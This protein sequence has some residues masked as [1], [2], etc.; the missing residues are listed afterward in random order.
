MADDL[1]F[2]DYGTGSNLDYTDYLY[3]IPTTSGVYDDWGSFPS[4]EPILGNNFSDYNQGSY[5][6][7]LN[8]PTDYLG[9]LSAGLSDPLGAIG[10]G[11]SSGAD[12]L[13]DNWKSALGTGLGLLGAYGNYRAGQDQRDLLK[14][15]ISASK[16]NT[17]AAL[18][19]VALEDRLAKA[20]QAAEMSGRASIANILANRGHL[21]ADQSNPWLNYLYQAQKE[22]E[23]TPQGANPFEGY[24]V[25]Q[26][27]TPYSLEQL[28]AGIQNM[29][30][31]PQF[32]GGGL[33]LRGALNAFRG[34]RGE[35]LIAKHL[36]EMRAMAKQFG[37]PFDEQAEIDY[38][39]QVMGNI[40]PPTSEVL[41]NDVLNNP[42]KRKAGGLSLVS[43][44][45]GG[46]DDLVDAKL[47]PSEYIFDADSVSALGDGNPEEGARKL[48]KMRENL[49]K[50]KR[51]ASPKKIPPRAKDAM[52][53]M[54]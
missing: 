47:S 40:L 17:R 8:S 29:S 26:K 43:G 16:A 39:N 18:A 30:S 52:D 1:Y 12:W 32:A 31:T 24:S 3:D 22:S 48:D 20:N 2:D 34:P 23:F 33:V 46:Q 38:L 54:E 7:W 11:I 14:S 35:E 37:K 45:G 50:H 28:M 53:Y 51:S 5:Q 41:P 13:G 27:V 36:D 25:G 15:Q 10:S 44:K 6:D 49:R 42:V 9:M 21:A 4:S 19:R